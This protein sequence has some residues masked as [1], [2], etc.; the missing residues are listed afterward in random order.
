MSNLSTYSIFPYIRKN[1]EYINY[2]YHPP[3]LLKINN[4]ETN[5]SVNINI[6]KIKMSILK[7]LKCQYQ[8]Y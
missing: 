6:K 3:I 4:P 8:K 2:H 5:E 7:I 1:P